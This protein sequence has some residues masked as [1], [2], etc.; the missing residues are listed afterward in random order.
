MK[1]FFHHMFVTLLM[2]FVILF[3]ACSVNE[4]REEDSFEADALETDSLDVQEDV[5]QIDVE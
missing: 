2:A 5:T 4:R 3:C 1:K